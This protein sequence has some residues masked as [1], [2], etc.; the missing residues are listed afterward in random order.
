MSSN[1]EDMAS[2]HRGMATSGNLRAAAFE[3]NDG[4]MSNLSLM[5]R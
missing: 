1:I 4:L 3:I 5:T 2:R